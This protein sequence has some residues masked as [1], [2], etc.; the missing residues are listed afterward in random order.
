[1]PYAPE[2]LHLVIPD[3]TFHAWL[4]G[5][6]SRDPKKKGRSVTAQLHDGRDL[7]ERLDW[8][9]E[10]E[11]KDTGISA[12]RHA[13]R[14]RDDFEALLDAIENTPTPD[15][16]VRICVAFEA[17]RYYRDLEAYVRIRNACF[18]AGVLLCYNGQVYD[19]SKRED[20]KATAQDAIDAE[21]EAEGIRNRNLRTARQ[22]AAKGAPWGKCQFGYMRKYD[23][24]TGDMVGQFEEPTNGPVVVKALQHI[25]SGRSLHSLVRWLREEPAAVR[26]DG[27][28]WNDNLAKYMLLNRAYLGERVH[29][30][31][32]IKAS[33]EPLKGLETPEGRALFRRVTKTLTATSRGSQFD[34]AQRLRVE[35]RVVHLLSRDALCGE[36]G[37]DHPLKASQMGAR[38]ERR[39][40]Y[41]CADK[42]D[43]SIRE[44][45][46]DAHTEE[47]LMQ[48]L[49]RKDVARAALIPDQAEVAQEVQRSQE[50]LDLF[51]EELAEARR[52]NRTRNEQ[53][54]PLL[55]LTALSATEQDLLPKIEDLQAKVQS[56][57]GVPLL[58]QQ[59]LG[60]ADPEALWYGSEESAGLTMEQKRE[61]IRHIVTVRLFKARSRGVRTIEP[62]RIT[63]SFIGTPGFRGVRLHAPGSV[64][65]RLGA[66]ASGTE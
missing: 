26:P 52:L 12:S 17:S 46:L 42:G 6:N 16:V 55:S 43:T 31:S 24:D 28:T 29:H 57:T 50:M 1:M 39:R 49:G 18:N 48:W 30:G 44:D 41:R 25:D 58:L 27:A 66:A 9:I 21:D 13:H 38:H 20:R 10:D 37:D 62:G 61:A 59:L 54:R 32:Y 45:V 14:S 53:G 47:G 5:R 3:V 8:Y 22:T 63:L 65:G 19:L 60:A 64:P 23:P 11:F 33:W 34:T 15:G 35:S 2:Y 36:C 56:A 7:C 51:E 40:I 4:Y